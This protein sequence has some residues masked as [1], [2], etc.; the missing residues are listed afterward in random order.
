MPTTLH[1]VKAAGR[2]QH[3]RRRQRMLF[4]AVKDGDTEKAIRYLQSIS[5]G[6]NG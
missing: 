5:G 3:V 2:L 1:P 4:E 6:Q